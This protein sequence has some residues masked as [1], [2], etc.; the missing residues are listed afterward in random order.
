MKA[1]CFCLQKKTLATYS[2]DKDLVCVSPS[3]PPSYPG[4]CVLKCPPT[5]SSSRDSRA[6]ATSFIT[7]LHSRMPS[8]C[9]ETIRYS[10][11]ALTP[12]PSLSTAALSGA[13]YPNLRPAPSSTARSGASGGGSQPHRGT[14]TLCSGLIERVSAAMASKSSSK[15]GSHSYSSTQSVP[16]VNARSGYCSVGAGGGRGQPSEHLE[17]GQTLPSH[18][19]STATHVANTRIVPVFKTSH[20]AVA[21]L[22]S[23]QQKQPTKPTPLLPSF[24]PNRSAAPNHMSNTGTNRPGTTHEAAKRLPGQKRIMFTDHSQP[25]P[26][27]PMTPSTATTT[28]SRPRGSERGTLSLEQCQRRIFPTGT[29]E[30]MVPDLQTDIDCHF[31]TVG[32]QN[33]LQYSQNQ[34]RTGHPAHNKVHIM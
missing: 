10:G 21:P 29:S 33:S 1:K 7:D 25:P 26:K 8:L 24:R 20:R 9:G 27:R 6:V 18:N 4:C 12:C 23:V 13:A 15:S 34:H 17:S 32:E 28:A 11:K 14:K 30:Q 22:H 3:P 19:G 2:Q 5:A 31:T 16:D